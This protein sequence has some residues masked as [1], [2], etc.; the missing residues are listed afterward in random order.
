MLEGQVGLYELASERGERP[1]EEAVAER[2]AR[3]LHVDRE[4]ET[5]SAHDGNEK[6]S[7]EWA[8]KRV[9]QGQRLRLRLVAFALGMLVLTPVWAVTEYLSAGSPQRLSPNDNPGDWSP[10]IIWVV[11]AW[12]FYVVL[13]AVALHFQRPVSDREVER[14]LERL[15]AQQ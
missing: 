6:E 14:E 12:G 13:S 2:R 4:V 5:M 7:R 15:T 10:W 9:R 3:A 1:Q 11:L 8:R